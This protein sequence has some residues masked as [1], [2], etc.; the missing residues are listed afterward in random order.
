M[1]G[2]SAPACKH[3]SIK[4]SDWLIMTTKEKESFIESEVSFFQAKGIPFRQ[5]FPYYGMAINQLVD[6]SGAEKAEVGN[7]L[8]S[9]VYKD[10]PRTHPMIDKM[11]LSGSG[12]LDAK[13]S[14]PAQVPAK[15]RQRLY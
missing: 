13:A 2:A 3:Q 6:M 5:P 12:V 9:I 7:L 10:D 1:L 14:A 11:K 4:G 8:L 15:T